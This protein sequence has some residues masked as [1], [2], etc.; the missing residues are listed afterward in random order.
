M[1][2][3]KGLSELS[4]Y[5]TRPSHNR[6][7]IEITGMLCALLFPFLSTTGGLISTKMTSSSFTI[8]LVIPITI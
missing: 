1:D 4:A 3:G 7:R 8:L 2:A 6:N 5:Y